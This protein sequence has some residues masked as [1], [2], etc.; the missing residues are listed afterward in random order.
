MGASS[1]R[2]GGTYERELVEHLK[3][4]G[5]EARRVYASGAVGTVLRRNTGKDHEDLRGDVQ[6]EWEGRTL[7]IEVKFRK[8]RFPQW[9]RDLQGPVRVDDWALY[10]GVMLAD[11][12]NYFRSEACE[13]SSTK[14]PKTMPTSLS[15]LRGNSDLLALRFPRSSKNKTGWVLARPLT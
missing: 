4:Q 10:P 5:Y 1:K 7:C 13:T 14:L 3:A 9:L 11:A 8:D 6:V 15:S 12:M 2:K